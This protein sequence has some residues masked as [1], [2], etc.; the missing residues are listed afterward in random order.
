MPALNKRRSA[1]LKLS[2]PVELY[3]INIVLKLFFFIVSENNAVL[4]EFRKRFSKA[5]V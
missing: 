3:F 2:V 5:A 4:V 1:F